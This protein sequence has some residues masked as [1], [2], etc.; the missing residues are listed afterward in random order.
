MINCG[1]TGR[2]VHILDSLPETLSQT[3]KKNIA[4]SCKL[5]ESAW[6]SVA[7]QQTYEF[8]F[9][10]LILK[11]TALYCRLRVISTY[12]VITIYM[13]I[14]YRH[15]IVIFLYQLR[16]DTPIS[17]SSNPFQC[18]MNSHLH[19][20]LDPHHFLCLCIGWIRPVLLLTYGPRAT[21]CAVREQSL[22]RDR[23]VLWL[24][25]QKK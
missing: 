13:A 6:N 14:I 2:R 24:T 11:F 18:W 8:T 21:T 9:V 1:C 4:V 7:I 22:A 25:P 19:I 15:I 23:L 16:C 12:L 5:R 3:K 17:F 20:C 10:I